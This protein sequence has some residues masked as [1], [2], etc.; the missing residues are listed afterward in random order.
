MYLS[1]EERKRKIIEEVCASCSGGGGEEVT[2]AGANAD[3]G[4]GDPNE[5]M[6][7]LSII[8]KAKAKRRKENGT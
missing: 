1:L 7:A 6:K 4:V 8:K 2:T 3:D 5:L